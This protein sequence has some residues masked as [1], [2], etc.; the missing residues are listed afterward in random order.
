M[1]CASRGKRLRLD[2]DDW[3]AGHRSPRDLWP[4]ADLAVGLLPHLQIAASRAPTRHGQC[5]HRRVGWRPGDYVLSGK[6]GVM[7]RT[8]SIDHRCELSIAPAVEILGPNA[9]LTLVPGES[10]RSRWVP[11]LPL[12]RRKSDRRP[13]ANIRRAGYFS[14]ACGLPSAASPPGVVETRCVGFIQSRPD[15]TPDPGLVRQRSEWPL[16]KHPGDKL[17]SSFFG[18]LSRTIAPADEERRWTT[19]SAG[20]SLNGV[21]RGN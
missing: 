2:L 4:V 20:I 16:C 11:R 7:T 5:R 17:T 18:A 15:D 10:R 14:G 8:A 12:S 19:V 3:V 9:G 21:S 1:Q 6:I 13:C